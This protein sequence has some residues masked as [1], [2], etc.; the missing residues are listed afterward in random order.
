ICK[1]GSSILFILCKGSVGE[2]AVLESATS[3][4]LSLS[5]SL[6]SLFL[7]LSFCLSQV[8][9]LSRPPSVSHRHVLYGSIYVFVWLSVCVCE[10]L[11][12]CLYAHKCLT[13]IFLL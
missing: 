6:A 11:C 2:E 7:A 3:H 5:V 9:P 12:V 4:L 8:S 1:L 10:C 13:N